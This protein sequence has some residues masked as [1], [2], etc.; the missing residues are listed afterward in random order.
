MN[1]DPAVT[2]PELYKVIFENDRVRVLEYR[3]AP[4]ARTHPHRHPDT[5]M[6]TLSSFR[7]RI[8]AG[9]REVEVELPAGQVRWVAAQE[10]A[11]EN[12]GDTGSHSIFIELKEPASAGTGSAG[13]TL[14]P[15]VS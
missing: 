11:G 1:H 10:H 7:R 6:Y 5:V 12:I 2:D 4:G 14:G 3:D 15:S 9:G 13:S 8:S